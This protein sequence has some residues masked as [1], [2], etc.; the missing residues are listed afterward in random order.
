[1]DINADRNGGTGNE[2]GALHP[3]AESNRAFLSH[4]LKIAHAREVLS[5]LATGHILPKECDGERTAKAHL[6]SQKLRQSTQ[7]FLCE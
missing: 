4:V 6:Q 5:L 1:M 2:L 7:S 3:K